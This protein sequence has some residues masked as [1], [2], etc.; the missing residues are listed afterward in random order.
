[1]CRKRGMA[2]FAPCIAER[3]IGQPAELNIEARVAPRPSEGVVRMAL[4]AIRQVGLGY[5]TVD[6]RLRPA[7]RVSHL[8]M[9][10][11]A[12]EAAG[13]I[14]G[15]YGDD[16]VPQVGPSRMAE[17]AGRGIRPGGIINGIGVG[18]S[19]IGPP[20]NRRMGRPYGDAIRHVARSG[21]PPGGKAAH[22][23]Y[24]AGEVGPVT[25][26]AIGETALGPGLR[27]GVSAMQGGVPPTRRVSGRSVGMA[28]LP[29]E[30]RGKATDTGDP[31]LQVAAVTLKTLARV[32]CKRRS[33]I[34][35]PIGGVLPG[36]VQS[37]GVA[38][39]AAASPYDECQS[40]QRKTFIEDAPNS[41]M[42]LSCF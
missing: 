11:G 32:A 29:V 34:D 30:Q 33:V 8:A 26:L 9:A 37:W 42:S 15:V 10:E 41:H 23:G 27:F 2:D 22:P 19:G 25:G 21:V 20:G 35:D 36:R 12:V 13:F 28:G 17:G 24:A 38:V 39:G 4:L 5:R 1:M 40:D 31:P 16:R 3:G 6:D 14:R 18:L 7:K